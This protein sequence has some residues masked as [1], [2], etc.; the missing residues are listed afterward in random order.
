MLRFSSIVEY[1]VLVYTCVFLNRIASFEKL[2]NNNNKYQTQFLL[3]MVDINNKNKRTMHK[4][5]VEM[6]YGPQCSPFYL[7]LFA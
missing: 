7:S 2:K 4:I 6:L 5:T 1:R 3:K